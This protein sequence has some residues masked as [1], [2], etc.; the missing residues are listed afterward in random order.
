MIA[1]VSLEKQYK[2][3]VS[4]RNIELLYVAADMPKRRTVV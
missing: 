4:F 3:F 1:A 2:M